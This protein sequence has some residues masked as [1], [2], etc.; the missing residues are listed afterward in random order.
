MQTHER[1]LTG[2]MN[3]CR[4]DIVVLKETRGDAEGSIRRV[5]P[6]EKVDQILPIR[7]GS[8]KTRAGVAV[9]TRPGRDAVLAKRL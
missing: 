4:P 9:I 3:T 1:E 7:N 2:L 6:G 5:W 8:R